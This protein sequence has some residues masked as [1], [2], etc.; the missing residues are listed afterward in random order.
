MNQEPLYLKIANQ[1]YEDIKDG[2]LKPGDKLPAIRDLSIEKQCTPGTIQ[3]AYQHLISQGMVFSRPG[4]GTTVA[5]PT[6]IKEDAPMRQALLLNRAEAFMLEMISAGYKPTEIETSIRLAMDHW[7]SL[8]TLD[9]TSEPNIVRF[10]G[11]HDLAL[12][13]IT[14]HFPEIVPPYHLKVDFCGS[15]GG[16]IA[17]A[18]KQADIAGIHLWDFETDSYNLPFIRRLLPGQDTIVVVF[19]YRSLGLILP[20]GNPNQLFELSDLIKPG[21]RFINRQPG[22]GTRVWL[23]A[24]LGEQ[25]IPVSKINGYNDVKYTHTEIARSV[26]EDKV[27][28]GIG[29]QTAAITFGLEF[30]EL[31]RERYDLVIPQQNIEIEGINRFV[32]W[33]NSDTAHTIISQFGGYDVSDTGKLISS[34]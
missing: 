16:L 23:D 7:L 9:I 14:A 27:D 10:A 6:R 15:L 22:S 1:I 21:L 13:W 18:Q 29:S 5:N 19:A 26:A 4:F 28:A 32:T 31:T 8:Q 34:I 33:L 25:A 17:L 11:S 2:K 3:R 24:K 12:N 30:I 20:P